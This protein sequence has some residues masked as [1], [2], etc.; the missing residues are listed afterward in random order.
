MP[1]VELDLEVRGVEEAERKLSM[2]KENFLVM[3]NRNKQVNSSGRALAQTLRAQAAQLR[4]YASLV[5]TAGRIT[6]QLSIGV[7]ILALMHRRVR[8]ATWQVEDAERAYIR[9]LREYGAG[10]EEAKEAARRL[11]RARIR[12]NEATLQNIITVATWIA[13]V[14]LST[15]QSVLQA[16][17]IQKVN[18]ALAVKTAQETA[19]VAATQAST[20]ADAA[21]NAVLQ[22][23][24]SL[25]GALTTAGGGLG[26]GGISLAGWG[27]IGA[28]MIGG[29]QFGYHVVGPAIEGLLRGRREA[30]REAYHVPSAQMGAEI[31]RGG[32]I[33]VE[34][35]ERVI[36][37]EARTAPTLNIHVERMEVTDRGRGPYAVFREFYHAWR[38]S[39]FEVWS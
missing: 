30:S 15:A 1:R 17:A 12:L 19:N 31:I 33:K 11:E 23:K 9:T 8:E 28:L 34:R 27:L 36:P 39:R 10:S 7:F 5:N 14:T 3:D 2:I 22:Q 29:A 37:A 18:Q 13:N 6:R 25:L 26:L 16:M 38:A 21:H 4:R 35:G 20:A 24:I 32:L